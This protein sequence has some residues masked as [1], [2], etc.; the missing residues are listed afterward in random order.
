MVINS[1][2]VS[3]RRNTRR[4]D[5]TV[6]DRV[7]KYSPRENGRSSDD[8]CELR[9][10]R[11]RS[12]IFWHRYFA[13][14]LIRGMLKTSCSGN[15]PARS[16]CCESHRSSFVS[17]MFMSASSSSGIE[18]DLSGGSLSTLGGASATVLSHARA[19]PYSTWQD[20]FSYDKYSD[21]AAVHS[22]YSAA[23][24]NNKRRRRDGVVNMR[25]RG[26]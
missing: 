13:D 25:E 23:D 8:T 12:P 24:A 3:G 16:G 26:Q 6:N 20:D 15:Y 2:V 1:R 14:S 10:G 11:D 5:A 4:I 9:S 21:R 17:A 22:R 7:Q 18:P 19:T